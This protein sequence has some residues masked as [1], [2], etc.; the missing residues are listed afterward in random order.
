MCI[1]MVDSIF[2]VAETNT[3]LS[4]NYTLVKINLKK[5]NGHPREVKIS[6]N[7]LSNKCF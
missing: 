5:F 2:C 3:T 4:G 7:L 6:V 1:C